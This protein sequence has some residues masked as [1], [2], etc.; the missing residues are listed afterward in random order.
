MFVAM[1]EAVCSADLRGGLWCGTQWHGVPSGTRTVGLG[2]LCTSFEAVAETFSRTSVRVQSQ[3]GDK[4]GL[5]S[6]VIDGRGR[7][8]RWASA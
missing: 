1:L 4:P 8:P 6:R 5:G 3:I 2:T 7:L